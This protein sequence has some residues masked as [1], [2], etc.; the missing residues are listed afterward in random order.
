[1]SYFNGNLIQVWCS[2]L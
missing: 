1:M 2:W